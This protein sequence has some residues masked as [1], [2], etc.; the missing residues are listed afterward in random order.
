MKKC[1]FFRICFITHYQIW[2]SHICSSSSSSMLMAEF[3]L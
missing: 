2:K 1:Q 3:C